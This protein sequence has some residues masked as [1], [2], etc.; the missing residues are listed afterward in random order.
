MIRKLTLVAPML[1]LSLTNSYALEC[2]EK[3]ENSQSPKAS[4]MI[5]CMKKIVDERRNSSNYSVPRGAVLA[6]DRDDLN[7]DECPLG[8]SPYFA[9]RGRVIIGA[10]DPNVLENDLFFGRNN[11]PLTPR[12]YRAHGGKETIDIKI[13]Q[14]P[15]HSH[16]FTGDEFE[17][18]QWTGTPKVSL[19]VGGEGAYD[20]ETFPTGHRP[21]VISGEIA[22]TGG[23]KPINIM[24]PY[25]ALYFCKKN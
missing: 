16:E 2:L 14:L 7:Q 1:L 10:G 12:K 21:F 18:G 3:L 25:V 15:K 13:P 11:E 4:E 19:S 5:Q 20:P 9:G 23:G 24:Q 22:E 17:R 8:W 6:F